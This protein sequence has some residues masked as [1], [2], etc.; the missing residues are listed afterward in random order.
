MGVGERTI[1]KAKLIVFRVYKNTEKG[2]INSLTVVNR[3]VQKFYG[4][5]TTNH[6]GK[7]RHHRHGLL[8]DIPHVK[9]ARSV[10]IVR[11]VDLE[12]ILSFLK[13]YN[14]EICTREITPT[15]DDEKTLNKEN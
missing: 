6:K 15:L 4:Q 12:K 5:D 13:V 9:L 14:A 11:E 8:E 2:T 3:F 7:Y 1:M 10:I